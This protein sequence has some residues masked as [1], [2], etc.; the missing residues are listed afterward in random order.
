M[1]F[2]APAFLWL[3][4]LVPAV[5]FL[6]RK[7]SLR[8]GILRAVIL[9]L[10]ALGAARPATDVDDERTH[11]VIVADLSSSAKPDASADAKARVKNAF[12]ALPKSSVRHLVIL[13][14]GITVKTL[15]RDAEPDFSIVAAAGGGSDL[16]AALAAADRLIPD[17]A[18]GSVLLLTDGHSTDGGLGSVVQ[19]FSARGVP[20]HVAALA[21]KGPDTYPTAIRTEEPL[22]VGRSGRV[23]ID[24]VATDAMT[25][26]TVSLRSADGAIEKSTDIIVSEIGTA[27]F[28]IEPRAAG[29]MQFTV[30]AKASKDMPIEIANG[31]IV[32]PV[33]LTGEDIDATNNSLTR[34]LPV[35]DPIQVLYMGGR[36]QGAMDEISQ[37]A[38]PGFNFKPVTPAGDGAALQGVNPADFDLVM[39]DDVP[40]A[41]MTADEQESLKRAVTDEGTGLILTGGEG[42]F[43]PG[44]YLDAPISSIVPVDYVQ[45]EEKRDPSTTLVIII[46]TSG[47]M[48]GTR[49]QLA[50]ETARL[51]MRRLLP[52][53]KCGIVEFH[54]AKRWAA[55]IQPASNT[56]DLQRAL[57]RL[58]AGGG[59][60][61]YPA[62]EE[63]FYALQNVQTRYKHVLILTDG[64]VENG[65]FEALTRQMSEK[66]ITVSTVLTGPEAHSEFLVNIAN[67]GKGRFYT[68]PSRSSLPEI[69]L[70]Q[71]TS[72]RLPAYQAG[73]FTVRRR[74]APAWTGTLDLE[75]APSIGGY[76]ETRAKAGAEVVL[77]TQKGH[78]LLASWRHGAGRVSTFTSE[79][80]GAGT[81]AWKEWGGFG[82]L[83]D[84]ML[85]KSARTARLPFEFRTERSGLLTT[86][87]AKGRVPD[88][89]TPEG[90]VVDER[91]NSVRLAFERRAADL[92]SADHLAAP[93]A[94]L[95]IRARAL[96][97]Q[98]QPLSA[99]SR[100]VR[101]VAAPVTS[102]EMQVDPAATTE[103]SAIADATGG[104]VFD[105]ANDPPAA[106]A[107][108][109]TAL[110]RIMR[111]LAPWFYFAALL[112][113]IAEIAWRRRPGAP[114]VVES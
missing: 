65:P 11:Y 106:P 113:W 97:A 48:G 46:D 89:I 6:P 82:P 9:A 18:K 88:A 92:W 51:A 47:S 86:V 108:S 61:I 28:V 72:A 60:I 93:G 68:A 31:Q 26:V 87:Y 42:S 64:G 83:L 76:V 80:A 96:G 107:A 38:G 21:R 50:K 8:A 112:L 40:A 49:I 62:F 55:P 35:E 57:N 19:R 36:T 15:A 103:L 32:G 66:G 17:D 100:E 78:P 94:E 102:A 71:P 59:T 67:W 41:R 30:V 45:K 69:I 33:N 37:L 12:A 84:R 29:F 58:N 95:K 53:D 109:G 27:E 5:F 79:L 10:T 114:Q 111:P 105:L 101:L 3:L 54:G 104:D 81:D 56:I 24:V 39:I 90:E 34:T 98:G 74:G 4:V 91:G 23:F 14:G 85:R 110:R 13:D 20:I 99:L 44:G 75:K 1:T 77:E 7:T 63:S 70:K 22:R 2:L 73:Q 52:H 43:G 25:P 16:S